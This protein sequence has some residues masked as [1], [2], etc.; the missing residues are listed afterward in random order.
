MRYV[1]AVVKAIPAT[2]K[3]ICSL[4]LADLSGFLQPRAPSPNLAWSV[5]YLYGVSS[6]S[7]TVVK[8]SKPC[9]L[10][11]GPRLHLQLFR[12]ALPGSPLNGSRRPRV[13][14]SRP[15][16]KARVLGVEGFF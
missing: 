12:R 8:T 14:M 7:M 15:L 9:I 6:I 5:K 13:E 16:D 1:G 3:A 11:L 10:L 2:C 4:C